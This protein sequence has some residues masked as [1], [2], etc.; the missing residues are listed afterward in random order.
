MVIGTGA[1][2]REPEG[3]RDPVDS[4]GRDK[5]GLMSWTGIRLYP[6]VSVIRH[7]MNRTYE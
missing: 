7:G 5:R 6:G 1:N 2:A 4:G 3:V